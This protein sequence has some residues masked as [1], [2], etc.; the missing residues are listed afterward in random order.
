MVVLVYA[1]SQVVLLQG[2]ERIEADSVKRD[3]GQVVDTL[4]A[5]IKNQE[6]RTGDW[7][8]WDDTYQF[9][10]DLNQGY[11]DRNLTY[12]AFASFSGSVDFVLFFDA[13]GEL[14]YSKGYDI[15]TKTEKPV[16]PSILDTVSKDKRLLRHADENSKHTGFLLTPDEPL[17]ITSFPILTSELKGPIRGTLVFV[18]SLND[19]RIGEL[20]ETLRTSLVMYR[21]DQEDLPADVQ[22][23]KE[24][25]LNEE[26]PSV[27]AL[28]NTRIAGYALVKDVHDQPA[29]IVRIDKPRDIYAKGVSALHYLGLAVLAMGLVQGTAMFWMMGS[30]IINPLVRLISNLR[31]IEATANLSGRVVA[32]GRDE[33][34]DL[35]R[36]VNRMMESLEKAETDVRSHEA[37]LRGLVETAVDGI[38]TADEQGRIQSFN[39]AAEDIF[40]YAADEVMGQNLAILMP[41]PHKNHHDEYMKTYLESGQPK[42]IGKGRDMLGLKKD[43]TV[44]PIYVALSEVHIGGRRLFTGIIRDIT[45]RK[46]YEEYLTHAAM[47]DPLTGLVNRRFFEQELSVAMN[48]AKRYGHALCLCMVDIDRFKDINDTYGHGVGDQVLK[49]FGEIIRQ[50]IRREDIGGRLGGDEFCICFT[51]TS[52]VEA[53]AC[54][55]RIRQRLASHVFCR[56][57]GRAFSVTASFGLADLATQEMDEKVLIEAADRSLYAAKQEGRNRTSINVA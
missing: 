28:D 9:V 10:S 4:A 2:F 49:R 46:R 17:M 50:E 8:Y 20:S 33:L 12:D 19:A 53:M 54:A 55:E 56:H 38:I 16:P 43:G 3:I 40:G 44:F 52:T 35:A 14:A 37:Q 27:R 21:V 23:A 24:V 7:A 18:A 47:H 29:L 6:A 30:T 34:A 57:T 11:V 32:H 1:W 22:E 51:H 31:V 48:S 15:E 26:A 42:L 13:K 25:I 45:E 5:Q 41:D 39:K 36:S